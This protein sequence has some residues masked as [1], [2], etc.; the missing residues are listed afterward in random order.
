ML[1]VRNSLQRRLC[2]D[3][4]EGRDSRA[5][6]LRQGR[7]ATRSGEFIAFFIVSGVDTPSERHEQLHIIIII[8]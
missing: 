5:R 2:Q 1:T 3:E 6:A 8:H 4:E 7:G